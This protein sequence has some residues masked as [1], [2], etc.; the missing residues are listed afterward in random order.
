MAVPLDLVVLDLGAR[1][2]DTPGETDREPVGG[3]RETDGRE[4]GLE[5]RFRLHLRGFAPTAV[6][7]RDHERHDDDERAPERATP[8]RTDPD[9][10]VSF[11]VKPRD[12]R[13]PAA[14]SRQGVEAAF[15][16]LPRAAR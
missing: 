9:Q 8:M 2:I 14:Y 12:N 15:D 10:D 4:D 1:R 13:P 6:T 16:T 7:A 3:R 5:S 11:T